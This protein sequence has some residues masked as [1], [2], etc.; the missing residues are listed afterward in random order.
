MSEGFVIASRY[1]EK[2]SPNVPLLVPVFASVVL[3]APPALPL[4]LLTQM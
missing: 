4:V 3:I 2:R 1:V